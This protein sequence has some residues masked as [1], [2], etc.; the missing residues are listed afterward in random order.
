[1]RDLKLEVLLATMN[2][3][4]D[5]ILERMKVNTDVLVCNQN[6]EK[7]GYKTYKKNRYTVRWY[8]FMER[9]VGLNRNNA[10]LRSTSDICLLA[11]DDVIYIDGYEKIVIN[12]FIK[13]PD[14]NVILFNI[15]SPMKWIGM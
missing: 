10:L 7:M 8:D 2:Q 5:D 4:N 3:K 14:V 13:H 12:E 15:Q 9:G 1:M 6:D 11:D